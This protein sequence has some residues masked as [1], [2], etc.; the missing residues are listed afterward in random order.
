MLLLINYN[1]YKHIFVLKNN[2]RIKD[3]IKLKTIDTFYSCCI[4]TILRKYE[5]GTHRSYK[6]YLWPYSSSFEF[7]KQNIHNIYCWAIK[8]NFVIHIKCDATSTCDHLHGAGCKESI[9]KYSFLL[10]AWCARH[11]LDQKCY[12]LFGVKVFCLRSSEPSH[13]PTIMT[14][15][16]Y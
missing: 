9:L 14:Y 5:I 15:I 7:I 6:H 10:L 16:L 1:R 2:Q 4:E 3:K 12:R 8:P 13:P 11:N